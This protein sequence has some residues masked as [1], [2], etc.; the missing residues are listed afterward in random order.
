MRLSLNH[1][2]FVTPPQPAHQC[3]YSAWTGGPL[4]V[5]W[6]G[7][8]Q[9]HPAIPGWYQ[10]DPGCCQVTHMPLGPMHGPSW[11][12]KASDYSIWGI[13]NL[14]P[15]LGV[16][17][18]LEKGCGGATLERKIFGS[19]RSFQLSPSFEFVIS[20]QG[21]W[22]STSRA[23]P[24]FYANHWHRTH[25]SPVFAPATGR[26]L[27]WLHSWMISTDSWTETVQ[28]CCYY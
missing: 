14:S 26:R 8:W 16:Y 13:I 7:I 1:F 28:R 9:L 27:C 5:F 3:W 4:A 24:V 22:E 23:A 11:T 2:C 18:E 12:V 25:S 6:F 19:H 15:D 20:G 10:Q 21:N 17:P